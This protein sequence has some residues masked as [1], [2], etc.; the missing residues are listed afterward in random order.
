M[1]VF[2]LASRM[3]TA[4]AAVVLLFSG[5]ALAQ[6][7]S[8]ITGKVTDSSGGVIP[9]A[10]VTVTNTS[11]D[12]SRTVVTSDDG[13]YRVSNLR[14]DRYIV[15]ATQTGFKTTTS[16]PFEVNVGQ[17]AHVDLTLE[18]GEISEE[19]IVT[20]AAATIE[21]E[22]GRVSTLVNQEKVVNL[23]LNGRNV[24]QLVQLSP[25]SVNAASTVSEPGASSATQDVTTSVNGGRV[26]MNGFWLDGVTA[27]NLS[28]GMSSQPSVDSVQEFRVE[29]LNFSA[30]Y[31]ASIGSVVN[32]VTKGGTNEFHGSLFEFHRN[33][34][35]DAR[36]FFDL[37]G[38]PEFK[39]N[40]FG[41]TFG[42][43]IIKDKTFFFFSYEGIRIRTGDSTLTTFETP[44][45]ASFVSNNGSP[46]AR[47]LYSNFGVGNIQVNPTSLG[48]YLTTT[49]DPFTGN[50][51]INLG[52]GETLTQGMVDAFLADRFGA[53]AGS[54][55]LNDP[56]TGDISIFT[57]QA[58]DGDQFTL[59]GDHDLNNDNKIFARY[60]LDDQGGVIVDPRPAF[61]SPQTIRTHHGVVSW[62]SVMSP[63]MVN[64][65]K[66]GFNRTINDILAGTPGV[67]LIAE[68]TGTSTFGAYN[69]YP[70]IFHENTF[71]WSDTLSINKGRHGIKA[72]ITVR[73]NQE[74]S[75]F[76]VGRPSYL[77]FD[78]VNLASDSPYYQIGG[79]N[80]NLP[81]VGGDGQAELSS[82]FRAWRGTEIGVFF[83]DDFK[84]RPNLTLNLGV[85]WDWFSR[86]VE[87]QG[88]TTQFDLSQGNDIFE[89]VVLGG[90]ATADQLSA[91]DY[92]N[93][94]PRLGLAWDP[95]GDGKM[96]VRAGY[97]IAYNGAVYN[98]LANSRWNPP[99]YSFNLICDPAVCGRPNENILYGPSGG[100]AVTPTGPNT[101][102]GAR[103]F[104]GNLIAYDPTNANTQFLSGIP[105]PNTRDPYTQSFF[106]GI[107]REIA[108][109]T[110]LE[111]NYVGTLGRKLIKAEFFNRFAG[112][113]LGAPSPVNGQ[114]EGDNGLNRLNPNF[115]RL[116]FWE[117]SVNSN[118]HALQ[119]QVDRRFSDG[120]AFN[121]N[122]TFS[123]SLD[124]RSTWHSGATS[125]NFTAEGFA[126]DVRNF[127][128]DY[129]RS[130]FD[131]RHR[132]VTNFI[133]QTPWL[134]NAGGVS[135]AVLGGWQFNGVVTLQ[136]GQPF[137][138]HF[139]NSFPAGGDF[140]ADGENND[141][142]SQGSG[143]NSQDFEQ[144]DWKGGPILS[145]SDF[146]IPQAG[147]VGTL[148]RNTFVGP[149]FANVDFSLFKEFSLNRFLN[150][151]SRLELRFEFF[152]LFNRP[153]FFQPEPRINNS[154]FGLVTD[155]FDAREIQFGLKV[156][157]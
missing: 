127:G 39:Q 11:T 93:F 130:I 154:Q 137:T 9:G 152:N 73:R 117:N 149:G 138:P 118:Y 103:G 76:N 90:F 78:L 139:A 49:V 79:V 8:S 141:R 84:V 3:L 75:E 153:N 37:G 16:R 81:E 115:G 94:A 116:R 19:V 146:V 4:A 25:G 30:E 110:S 36:E 92:N 31:G 26:N 91:N 145:L 64:E 57:P 124:S 47:F 114:F 66:A 43:P 33:D 131:S 28:G 111:V 101:N 105:N 85:R 13:I 132:F 44:Q 52:A 22:Q 32:V 97:G 80:P 122:Y 121:A 74:N 123:K 68:S 106:L 96:S 82:N 38:K 12:D 23:P 42:G 20:D 72:G 14:P 148:G 45:W 71:S 40:Q 60:F 119:V 112:D 87:D 41:A 53:P 107:Q 86:L 15:R 108:K 157:F 128:L 59:R 135:Q 61:N 156:V 120:F 27:K 140:N 62:T 142:P 151:E 46:V 65:A 109:D 150:E 24:M 2:R 77:F 18:V 143:G 89:R 6:A 54:F 125:A 58:T 7:T 88:R 144:G 126:L 56:I 136:A 34:N 104:E 133:Y 35:A 99:F 50:P 134:R 102:P 67:P 155:T 98:P 48:T 5:T 70:Q 51:Y 55:G 129:G 21:L 1:K 29:T 95:F 69:G 63:T 100:G 10:E 83:N 147:T 113:R 17:V